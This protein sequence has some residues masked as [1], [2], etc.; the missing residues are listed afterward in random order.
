VPCELNRFDEEGG[1]RLDSGS[2]VP[3][4][5]SGSRGFALRL[6][7]GGGGVTRFYETFYVALRTSKARQSV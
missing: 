5:K 4:P 3:R 7:G 6:F 1:A 2:F